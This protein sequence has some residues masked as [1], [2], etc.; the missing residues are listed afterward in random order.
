MNK[1]SFANTDPELNQFVLVCGHCTNHDNKGNVVEIN[2]VDQALYYKC[3]KCKKM[4]IIDFSR[5]KPEPYPR[6][7]MK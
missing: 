4:N 7:V 1:D 5:I 2:F 3:T 6:T